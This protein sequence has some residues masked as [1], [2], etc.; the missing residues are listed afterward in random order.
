MDLC[1][2]DTET[3]GP[4]FG[5]HELLEIAAVRTTHDGLIEHGVWYRRLRPLHVDRLTDYARALTGFDPLAARTALTQTRELWA[6]FAC[7]A[8][9]CVPVC[10]NPSFDRAFIALAA[11]SC[12]VTDLGLDYHWIGTETMAWPLYKR[13]L[14]P[15]LSLASICDYLNIEQEPAVHNAL[16]GAR[17]CRQV[18]LALVANPMR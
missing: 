9:D 12:G 13:G 3:T 17:T 4:Q 16:D 10:H 2:I 6:D 8:K 7:F 5:H 18:Y 11:A 14:F 1:F 15:K